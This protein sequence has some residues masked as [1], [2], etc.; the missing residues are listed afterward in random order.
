MNIITMTESE[1]TEWETSSSL[2]ETSTSGSYTIL[3]RTLN[4]KHRAYVKV[5]TSKEADIQI[6]QHDSVGAIMEAQNTVVGE[7][8]TNT[9]TIIQSD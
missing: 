4:N 2:S 5:Q 6:M 7:A 3:D 8:N 1:K 9:I